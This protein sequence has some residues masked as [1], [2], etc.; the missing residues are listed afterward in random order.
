MIIAQD[1]QHTYIGTEHLLAALLAL[2]DSA[3]PHF[4]GATSVDFKE[5]Q[6]QVDT[7]ISNASHFPHLAEVND[8]ME[9]M[10]E[11]LP[12]SFSQDAME[13]D[14][15][16]STKRGRRKESALEFFATHLTNPEAQ[17]NIDPVIGRDEEIRRVMQVLS[18]RTK[19]NPVLIGEPGVGKTAIVEGLA[20]RI[21]NEEVPE[22]LKGKKVLVL[23]MAGLLAGAKYRGEFEERLKAV[24]KD[25]AAGSW[26]HERLLSMPE[27]RGL[28]A[29][30]MATTRGQALPPLE[31]YTFEGYRNTDGTVGTKNVLGIMTSVQ[32]VAGVTDFAVQRIKAELLPRYP[33]VDDVVA[34]EHGYGCGVAIDAP[35]AAIPIR[36]LRHISLNPNFGGEVM[37]VSLGC[38]KL[39]PERLFPAD[40]IPIQNARGSGAGDLDTVCL[41]DDAHVG[42]M[43]MVESILRQA[44]VHLQRRRPRGHHL[45]RQLHHLHAHALGAAARGPAPAA[46]P[47]RA[48]TCAPRGRGPAARARP[49]RASA[50]PERRALRARARDGAARGLRRRTPS[51]CRP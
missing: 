4:L 44:E 10:Q 48:S 22:T 11:N 42:F 7:V 43:S 51:G 18:R 19:N 14:S 32:C 17:K 16:L 31:G 47:C 30:P 24:L 3:T 2:S 5:L 25:I 9:R 12:D 27:A 37:V 33:N 50:G 26:V 46:A 49:R 15:Q 21:V 1:N 39:Q 45:R 38:E 13:Q 35:D 28:D 23:D 34:L 29:L 40:A 8:V 41:Q 20:Q 6:K 36:T